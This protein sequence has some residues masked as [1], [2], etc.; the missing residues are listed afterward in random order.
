MTSVYHTRSFCRTFT[1]NTCRVFYFSLQ[2]L[3]FFL[4]IFN[5]FCSSHWALAMIDSFIRYP[6]DGLLPQEAVI[7]YCCRRRSR[8]SLGEY[9]HQQA[10]SACWSATDGSSRTNPKEV[11]GWWRSWLENK[12]WQRSKMQSFTHIGSEQIKSWF[13]ALEAA[14]AAVS[15]PRSLPPFNSP[16]S[17][18][19][20]SSSV[21]DTAPGPFFFLSLARI[22]DSLSG[23]GGISS[24]TVAWKEPE[25]KA[26]NRKYKTEC[27]KQ[28][29]QQHSNTALAV[30]THIR[31]KTTTIK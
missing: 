17:L 25:I 30:A 29:I 5:I 27:F 1:R 11:C 31:F 20:S 28:D 3:F 24:S 21:T 19:L 15:G 14:T 6:R 12:R 2:I 18:L 9:V 13:T 4:I 26:A 22:D 23:K 7:V 10:A 8:C 16:P